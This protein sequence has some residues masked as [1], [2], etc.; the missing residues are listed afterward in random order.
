MLCK[1]RMMKYVLGADQL[2]KLIYAYSQ[3]PPLPTYIFYR[4]GCISQ[5][6]SFQLSLTASVCVCVN[7]HEHMHPLYSKTRNIPWYLSCWTKYNR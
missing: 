7:V 3:P 6:I 1:P 4:G 5:R 2:P